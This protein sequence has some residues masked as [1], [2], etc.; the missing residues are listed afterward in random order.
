MLYVLCITHAV[1]KITNIRYSR[2]GDIQI[3]FIQRI[4]PTKAVLL[5]IL[6]P[7]RINKNEYRFWGVVMLFIIMLKGVNMTFNEIIYVD[8]RNARKINCILQIL[9][10]LHIV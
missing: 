5:L 10:R 3:K 8:K 9:K 6:K 7:R 4:V 2:K 1:S